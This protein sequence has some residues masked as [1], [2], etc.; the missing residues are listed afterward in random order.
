MIEELKSL[1][2][3]VRAMLM[4][5]GKEDYVDFNLDEDDEILIIKFLTDTNGNI[6]LTTG[7]ISSIFR[8]CYKIEGT[9]ENIWISG[10][11]PDR[12]LIIV[13]THPQNR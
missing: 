5:D 11:S 8:K 6:L 12:H 1:E 3:R 7:D 2:R 4:A 9:E 10:Y 13:R